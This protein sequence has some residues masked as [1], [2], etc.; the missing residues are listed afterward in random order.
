MLDAAHVQHKVRLIGIDA[1]ESE[2]P[3][4]TVSK[5]N[6]GDL[7]FG[8]QVIVEYQ[9]KDRYGL[10]LGKILSNR[11]DINLEQVEDGLAWHYKQYQSDQSS[12]DREA[13]AK[14]EIDARKAGRGLW[15]DAHPIPPW[16]W[17]KGIRPGASKTVTV[18]TGAC[19]RRTCGQFS[20][21]DDA[22]RYVRQCGGAGI[23]GDGDG[24]PCESMCR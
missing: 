21:C 7:V 13:Y 10:K 14:I 4:G 19:A 23:D 24:V 16:D 15:T 1:P 17:R 5:Q 22:M 20:S 2:Q 6:L 11:Q 12:A 8:R 3:F 9:D 18:P